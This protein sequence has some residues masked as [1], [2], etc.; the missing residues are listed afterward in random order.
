MATTD[1][2]GLFSEPILEQTYLDPGYSDHASDVWLVRT[3]RE[4]V[5]VRIPRFTGAPL[6]EFGLGVQ[7]LFGV[8]LRSVYDLEAINE[9][10]CE[11]SPIPAPRVLRKGVV[12]GRP[13]VVVEKMPGETVES[14][15]DLPNAALEQFGRDLAATHR[16]RF[17]HCG[18]PTGSLRYPLEEFHARVA[19][20]MKAVA[21]QCYRNDRAITAALE[22]T[23]VLRLP[24]PQEAALILVDMDARQFLSDG[25]RVTAVVDTEAYAIGP[26]E[27]D[28]IALEY[29]LDR[30]G[31]GAVARGYEALLPLPDLSAVRPAYRFLYRLFAVQGEVD[32]ERWMA[33]E[34]VFDR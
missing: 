14:F 23:A 5:V 12:D 25:S 16:H 1:L 20:T 18:S 17:D 6:G 7:R 11:I 26:P 13:C 10:V 19:E 4:E 8:N 15:R 34:P 32:L 29:V 3:E 9:L 21:A 27:L 30:E 22:E 24:P 28:F 33:W 31:A 2:R